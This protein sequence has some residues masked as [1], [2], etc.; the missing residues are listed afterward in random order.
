MTN[1]LE[2]IIQEKKKTLIEIKKNNSLESLEDKIKTINTFLDFKNAI[3]II[4]KYLL[5]LKLKKQ[6]HQLEYWFKILIT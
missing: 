3:S 5:Y 6:V 4:R 1:I 2:K